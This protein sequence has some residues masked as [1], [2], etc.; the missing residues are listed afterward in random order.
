MDINDPA[1]SVLQQ[2]FVDGIWESIVKRG[3]EREG[4]DLFGGNLGIT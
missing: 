4:W 1:R 3:L 2:C